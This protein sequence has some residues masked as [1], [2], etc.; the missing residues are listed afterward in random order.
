[1]HGPLPD[2]S[3]AP[4]AQARE[5]FREVRDEIRWRVSSLWPGGD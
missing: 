5:V 2:P 1:V 4:E 3:K